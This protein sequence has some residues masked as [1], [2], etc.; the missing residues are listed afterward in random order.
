MNRR[1]ALFILIAMCGC[2]DDT[3]TLLAPSAECAP[4]LIAI[5]QEPDEIPVLS[6]IDGPVQTMRRTL[7]TNCAGVTLEHLEL[8]IANEREIRDVTI[9]YRG[10]LFAPEERSRGYATFSIQRSLLFGES[11]EFSINYQSDPDVPNGITI[12]G[13]TKVTLRRDGE[14]VQ[15]PFPQGL[16]SRFLPSRGGN[17]PVCNDVSSIG[18]ID[19]SFVERQISLGSQQYLFSFVLVVCEPTRTEEITI[20]I[21]S[22]PEERV[23]LARHVT[24]FTL[25]SQNGPFS[26]PVQYVPDMS[27]DSLGT[28]RIPFPRELEP[29]VYTWYVHADVQES[30]H[31]PFTIIM[32]SIDSTPM[33]LNWGL[34]IALLPP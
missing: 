1:I 19:P 16:V 21:F 25:W 17:L 27:S 20:G 4:T 12:L 32:E 34:N 15:I 11:S 7:E 3:S 26:S 31:D 5:G 30:T 29:G 22:R 14:D 18:G 6:P 24:D 9:S 8:S 13:V 23:N 28:V 2:I 10:R 33:T